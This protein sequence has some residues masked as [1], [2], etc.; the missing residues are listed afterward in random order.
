MKSFA[1]LA[2]SLCVTVAIQGQAQKKKAIPNSDKPLNIL[3]ILA[4]DYGWKDLSCTGSDYYETPNLDRIAR[5]G[6]VFTQA[7]STCQ[8]SSPSRASIMTGCYTPR[9]NITNYIG[10]PSG[11]N[12]RRPNR[13]T[14]LLPPEYNDYLP[15]ELKTIAQSMREGGYKTFFAGKWH[16]GGQGS[17]PEDRGFDINVGGWESGGPTGGYFSP[18][19]NPKLP[20]ITLGEENCMRLAKETAN[21]I[22]GQVKTNQK[23]PF[24]A[25]L[26]FYAVHAPIETTHGYW[27]HFRD[28]AVKKGIAE[29]GFKK[30]RTL[31]VRQYQDNPVYAGLVK[32][33]DDAVGKVLKALEY[34][35]IMENTLIIFTSDN[36]GVSRGDAYASCNLPLRGGKGT[37]WE[38]GIRVPL[39]VRMP[40]GEHADTKCCT[41]VISTD[42]YPTILDMA[43]LPLVPSIHRDGVSLKNLFY[44]KNITERPLYWHYPHYGN[45]GGEPS[46]IIRQGDWKLIY[47]HEDG[48]NELYNLKQDPY[49][50]EIVNKRYSEIVKCLRAQLDH[51]LASTHATMPIPDP[52]YN[53]D[54]AR[55]INEQKYQNTLTRVEALRLDM[56]REDWQP[57]QDWWG[58]IVTK[59]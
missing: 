36:G 38:A 12:W 25:Y 55:K 6:I 51:W 37:Q 41:P 4:D 49:E 35:G 23:Q 44:G 47:Y 21:F 57:N 28:K 39:L 53:E 7:Y 20:N 45:Q 48:R 46:S 31:P 42:F 9:H 15:K 14:K 1:I 22:N 50:T 34:A 58:S 54:K 3:F 2:S 24:F 10:A 59:D 52:Q 19:K 43:G 40:H 8:V 13:L 26:S 27:K 32:Q 5:E 11:E 30:D 17:Y 56:L 29:T 18:W 16:L 33:M